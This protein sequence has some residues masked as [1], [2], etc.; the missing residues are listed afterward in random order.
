ME[1][2]PGEENLM[3]VRRLLA[4]L[5]VVAASALVVSPAAAAQAGYEPRFESAPCPDLPKPV[6]LPGNARCGF[7]VV[8]ENR[9]RPEGRTIRLAV[10][11][12]PA[13]SPRP[14]PDPI[15]HLTGGPG[16][17]AIAEAQ[18][19]VDAGFNRDRDLILMNQR[20][21][22]LSEPALTC[23]VI[24]RFNRLQVGLPLDARSTRRK[25]VAATR[26]CR[27]ELV[28]RGIDIAAYNTTENA[29]DFADLRRALG[30]D[31]WNAFGVSYGTYL[32]QTI[33]R[34][35]PEGLRSVTLDSTVPLSAVDLADFWAGARDGLQ[36][37]FGA[38]RAQ[39][40]CRR[41]FPNL[42]RTFTML[43]R[44]LESDPV[45]TTVADPSTRQPT[46]VVLDGGALANWLVG[47]SFFTPSFK[48]VPSWIAGLAAGDPQSIAASR[49]AQVTA[50]G[51]TGFG[52]TYGVICREWVPFD[53]EREVLAQGGDVLPRY[54]RSVLSQPPQFT[55]MFD[56]CR[57]WDVPA[58]PASV[59][60][61]AVSDIPTLILSGS[62]DSVTSLTW[63]YAAAEMLPNSRIAS[64]PG[65]G[66][67][68]APES[69]CAQAVIASFLLRPDAPDTNCVA[70]LR[71]PIFA[72]P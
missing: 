3:R 27:A 14:A 15:V 54:P 50:P 9:S 43:V 42:E 62:F 72:T 53:S 19:L 71:P 31:R 25:H 16:G 49:L 13:V 48:D 12:V 30:Y 67:F 47:M 34:D 28:A 40:R 21:T 11:I 66:H 46:P 23:E 1:D 22:F 8:P 20:G 24:D 64:I 68:V 5:T 44:R 39:A 69:P 2:L 7:L 56:D 70:T 38:C 45:R 63:A 10:A 55:Y 26:E 4:V 35:H 52:L 59:R 17:V 41:S 37:I 18:T 61:P 51:L 6:A 32:A 29:A 65:V 58:A 60:E 57:V 36:N 33:M